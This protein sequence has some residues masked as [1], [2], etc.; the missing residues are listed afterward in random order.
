MILIYVYLAGAVA[1]EDE[2]HEKAPNPA[3]ETMGAV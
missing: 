1:I 3:V 2:H